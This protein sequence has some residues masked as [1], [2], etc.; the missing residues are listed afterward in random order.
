MTEKPLT[1]SLEATRS[2]TDPFAAI[3]RSLGDMLSKRWMDN[4]IPLVALFMTAS[5]FLILIPGFFSAAMITDLSRQFAETGLV[6]LALTIVILSG[7]IDLSIGAIFG[8]A[9]LASAICMNVL[10]L[11]VGVSFLVVLGVGAVCG[12]VNGLLVGY[13]RLRAFLTTLVM[14]VIFRSVYELVFPTVSTDIVVNMPS[15]DIWDFLGFGSVAG[16]PGTFLISAL[17]ILAWH[18]VMTRSRP[19]WRIIAV[20]SARRSAHNLG[21][22]VRRTVCGAYM[23][24]GMLCSVAGF[25]NAARLG[26]AG[27]DTG[28]GVEIT[29]LTAV[30]LGG[31]ALGG[32]RG[33][34]FKAMLGTVIVLLLTNG[35]ILL[36]VPGALNAT[37]LGI[38]LL[39]AV[40]LDAR[41][42]RFLGE[43]A[44]RIRTTPA[45]LCL[46]Q[47][48]DLSG[49]PVSYYQPSGNPKIGGRWADGTTDFIF[50]AQ[51]ELYF[52]NNRGE[53][54][55]S[56]APDY[57]R[58]QVFSH[59]GGHPRG[60]GH[61]ADGTMIVCVGG[62]GLYRV[63]ADGRNEK[64]AD[65]VPS[66]PFSIHDASRIKFANRLTLAPDGRIIFTD[67]TTRF[68]PHN[69]IA[70]A[71]EGRG[72]GRLLAYD[73]ASKRTSVLCKGLVFPSGVCMHPDG[74]S[75]IVAERFGCRL[76]RHHFD[77]PR[78]GA[79]DVFVPSLP[80]YPGG[81]APSP[82]GGFLVA[83]EGCRTPFW[84]LAM[85]EPRFRRDVLQNCSADLWP[86]P[87][88]DGGSVL[89]IGV[90]GRIERVLL[91]TDGERPSSIASARIHA[92]Q[93]FVAGRRNGSLLRLVPAEASVHSAPSP[94]RERA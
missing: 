2:P 51:G 65:S 81:I 10:G 41:W 54:I 79:T 39:V 77:G 71:I 85:A 90:G 16:L 88:L 4:A 89:S 12:T 26:G 67:S 45:G 69:W 72:N 84:D 52:G 86:S 83:V 78:R 32:G 19:G 20:G 87:N 63:L 8:L 25:F 38:I 46:P 91:L 55:R 14:M 47:K 43:A 5:V 66:S 61:D 37:L 76:L 15:S 40:F 44:K 93:L 68:E 62:M 30:V 64:L 92:G 75:V 80:G 33:T 23:A 82:Q 70:D 21:I 29:A 60:L 3:E 31:I 11:P 22:P 27:T 53:I 6:V 49:V 36:G 58:S 59:I 50:G 56:A 18:L 7:G 9:A 74:I 13:V 28:V 42:S 24:S 34:V 1:A 94:L 35:L 48:P 57:D 73:P 17:I